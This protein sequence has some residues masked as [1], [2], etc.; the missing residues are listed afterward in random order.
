MFVNPEH[1]VIAITICSLCK[2]DG[3]EKS[4][5]GELGEPQ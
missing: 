4:E 3:G 2:R 1:R 5:R